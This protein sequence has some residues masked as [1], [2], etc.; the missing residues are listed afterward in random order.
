MRGSVNRSKKESQREAAFAKGGKTKMF[1]QQAAG[2][3]RPGN[4][5]KDQ[6]A[7]PGAKFARGGKKVAVGGVARPARA[8]STGT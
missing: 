6:S 5:E 7:A 8:G 2:P 1:K 4:T 3:D